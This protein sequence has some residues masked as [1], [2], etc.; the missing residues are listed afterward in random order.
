M[1]SQNLGAAE[2]TPSQNYKYLTVNSAVSRLDGAIA[3]RYLNENVTADS[4]AVALTEAQFLGNAMFQLSGASAAFTLTTIGTNTGGEDTHRVFT[5]YN[6]DT[7][8]ACTIQSD[9]TGTTVEV[10]PGVTVM[11]LQI[12]DD[13]TLIVASDSNAGVPYDV[14]IYFPGS[15]TTSQVIGEFYFARDAIIADNFAG[16]YARIGTNPTATWVLDIAKNGVDVGDLSIGTTGTTTFTTDA[17]TISMAAGDRLTITAPA[18]VDATAADLTL[19]IAAE[20]T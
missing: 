12:E 17:T 5:V 8:Y 1:T 18:S 20:L 10:L 3:G 15:P 2:L 13:I 7:T 6:A 4:N 11:V 19:T 14:G 9:D 16:S